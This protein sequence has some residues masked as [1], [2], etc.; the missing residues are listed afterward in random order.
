M[1]RAAGHGYHPLLKDE[2]TPINQKNL[3]VTVCPSL[4]E[5]WHCQAGSKGDKHPK[6]RVAQTPTVLS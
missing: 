3:V 5:I 6:A 1:N 4:A 2:P